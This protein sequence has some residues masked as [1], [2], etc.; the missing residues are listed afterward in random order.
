MKQNG[1]PIIREFKF[2]LRKLPFYVIFYPTS[3]CNANCPHCFNYARQGKG[4]IK[5]ELSLD[6]VDK[7]SRKFGHIKVLTITGGEPFLRDDLFEIVSTFHR[8]NGLQ[9]VSFHTNGF[10]VD[11]VTDVVSRVLSKFSDLRVIVCISIDGV[12]E[13]HDHFRGIEKSFKKALETIAKLKKL[14]SKYSN[15]HLVSSTIF[16]K[17]T[18][19]SFPDTI[20]FIQDNIGGVKPSLSFIRGSV[21]EE[22]EKAVDCSKYEDFYRNFRPNIDKR[23]NPFSPIAVKDAI[24]MAV[25][26][27]VIKNYKSCKQTVACQS[28]R[29][30]VVIYEN[31]DVYPCETLSEEFGNLRDAEYDIKKLL[32]SDKAKQILRKINK[33][34]LC[35]CTWENVIPINLL[36]DPLH[37]PR[38]FY[39][40][41]RLFILK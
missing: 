11:K 23:I 29:K 38:I 17:T 37:Y 14:K 34:K 36:F 5:K 13:I 9:Y 3:R 24:E 19:T 8:N 21:K 16:S 35:Y 32:F 18:R 6:E 26:K 41:L 40:W 39:E 27:I 1:F 22:S 33:D 20:R 12:G 28:G 25:N 2:L 4:D 30:L 15:L 31:G 7:I 10:L